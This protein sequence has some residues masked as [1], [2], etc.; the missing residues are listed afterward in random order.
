MKRAALF[1]LAAALLTC[2]PCPAQAAE[3]RSFDEDITRNA[4]VLLKEGRRTF[5]NDTFGDEA[6]W[7]G[8]LQLHRALATLTPE[9]ALDAGLKVNSRRL[10]REVIDAIRT[11][12]AKLDDPSTTIALLPAST[13]R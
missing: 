7:G 9:Q 1:P 4:I 12:T 8:Q 11:G 13:S 2:L 3:H 5:R 10:S 6:F